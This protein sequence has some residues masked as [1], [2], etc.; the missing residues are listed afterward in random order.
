MPYPLN[1]SP[2]QRFRFEQ[3]LDALAN[4]GY[5]YHLQTFLDSKNWRYFF[6]SGHFFGK[7]LALTKGFLKR[8]LFLV[9]LP[10]Y[11]W[12]F[13]H[14]EASPVGPPVFEWVIA[15]VYRKNIIYDFDDAIWLTDRKNESVFLRL[16]KW[17]SKV[18]SICKWSYRVSA[19]NEYLCRYARQFNNNVIHNPTTIDTDYLHNPMTYSI[20]K[21]PDKVV[22]G[23]TG[24]HSTLK[25]LKET[26]AALVD[27][28]KKYPVELLVIA[29]KPPTLTL[30]KMR[31]IP[32]SLETEIKGLLEADIGIMPLPNDE[33]AKGKCGFKAL[34]YMALEIPVVASPV[35]VNTSIIDNAQN[36]F[37]C[38]GYQEW[39]SRLEMLIRD[40]ALRNNLGKA[41]RVTV[42]NQYSV[43]AN[44][45]N[46][47][48]LFLM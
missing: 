20:K 37:L 48:S 31:F 46:F 34:Q 10:A 32:W 3:Y 9:H 42:V 15:K 33:W 21:D 23:W 45:A 26:E 38:E 13:I 17:R 43:Q 47:L 18:T 24:S 22:I 4:A 40:A 19:G 30:S 25:Y 8:L 41:G 7:A 16:V 12:V 14:R 27:L 1:E 5:S 39:L 35:G 6:K 11:D 44:T 2:S 29:D 36:G 28:E